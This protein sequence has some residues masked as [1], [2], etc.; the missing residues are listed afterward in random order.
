M[1]VAL[2]VWHELMSLWCD[3]SMSILGCLTISDKSIRMNSM[4]GW[5]LGFYNSILYDVC[6]V[7]SLICKLCYE[8]IWLKFVMNLWF[9]HDW[10]MIF[11]ETYLNLLLL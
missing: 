7:L 2:I 11:I 10:C 8:V 5:Y 4:D 3:D 9:S 6:V 1:Y